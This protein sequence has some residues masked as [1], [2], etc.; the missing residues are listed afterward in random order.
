MHIIIHA[1]TVNAIHIIIHA[2][3]V[4]AIHI[5]I[6]AITV[7]AMHIIH[8]LIQ[9]SRRTPQI[10]M[11]SDKLV[12]ACPYAGNGGGGGS[13]DACVPLRNLKITYPFSGH[14]SGTTH[15]YDCFMQIS[16]N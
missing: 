5:I 12:H 6:H 2:I 1:I 16:A 14:S 7:N 13:T 10:L 9:Y 3:T 8:A 15:H 11:I 4:N